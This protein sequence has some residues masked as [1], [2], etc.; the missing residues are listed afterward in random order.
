MGSRDKE[1]I[2]KRFGKLWSGKDLIKVGDRP[3]T[4]LAVKR[5]FDLDT[6]DVVEIDLH[7]V[8]EGGFAFRFYD[9]DDRRI[10]VFVFNDTFD[11][12]EEHRV[13][14]AEWLGDDYY[15]TGMKAFDPDEMMRMLKAKAGSGGDDRS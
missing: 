9:G 5:A 11:I 1:N 4:L 8:P 2:D 7:V 3:F 10:V 15:D 12:I 14:I 13:H 6:G